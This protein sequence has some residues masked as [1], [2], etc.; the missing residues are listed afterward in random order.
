MVSIPLKP[1]QALMQPGAIFSD[2][3]F[4]VLSPI[5]G[6]DALSTAGVPDWRLD[7][8]RLNTVSLIERSTC[9]L[10]T[11]VKRCT[12]MFRFC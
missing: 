7:S 3:V 11:Y 8:V 12:K 6:V 1:C 5:A 4:L 9:Q 10:Y 2:V